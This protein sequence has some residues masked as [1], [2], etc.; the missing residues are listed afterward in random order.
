MRFFRPALV[1]H[2]FSE[3]AQQFG[4]PRR[5]QRFAARKADAWGRVEE[6]ASANGVG[7]V[8]Y[9]EGGNAEAGDWMR[10]PEFAA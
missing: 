3:L 4:V 2:Q 5:C 8:G 1:A 10:E 7:A 9:A 6:L